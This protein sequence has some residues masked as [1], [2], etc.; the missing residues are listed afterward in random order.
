MAL[1]NNVEFATVHHKIYCRKF[2]TLSNQTSRCIC[3][4][5]FIVVYDVKVRS[6]AKIGNRYNQLP[7]LTY[8][9]IW[10]YDKIQE[11]IAYKRPKRSVLS[12]QM[13]SR[14]QGT[15]TNNERI[16]KKHRLGM[17]SIF[18]LVGLNIFDGTKL[19]LFSDWDQVK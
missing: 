13:T 2:V 14:L 17:V 6:K 4:N 11:N 10:E 12:Q 9:A 19:T 3:K 7:T 8:D 16:H 15:H 5:A 1:R 18:L